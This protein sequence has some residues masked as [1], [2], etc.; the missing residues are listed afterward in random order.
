MEAQVADFRFLGYKI[1]KASID[2]ADEKTI[3]NGLNV[4]FDQLTAVGDSNKLR[5]TMS[6]HISDN[7]QCLHIDATMYGV[8]EFEKELTAEQREVF[9][10]TNAP[11]ILFPYLRSYITSL[12]ALAGIPP[13]ILPTFNMTTLNN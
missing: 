7:N 11:A 6:V 1:S 4:Q 5:H 8:F 2:I 12:T 13:I 10:K 3:S 9:C